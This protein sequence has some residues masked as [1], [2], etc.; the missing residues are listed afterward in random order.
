MIGQP[1]AKLIPEERMDEEAFILNRI[2]RGERVDTFQT[3]R[4]SKSRKTIDISLTISPIKNKT[5]KLPI[6]KISETLHCAFN[7]LKIFLH[8]CFH[9]CQHHFIKSRLQMLPVFRNSIRILFKSSE[10][11]FSYY[12][13][14]VF[15]R[16]MYLCLRN[17]IFFVEKI[18]MEAF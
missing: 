9:P 12:F 7:F 4:I 17:L 6:Y 1:I 2:R 8:P 10:C 14:T 3:K 15:V 16:T 18:R 11:C 13:F 5:A